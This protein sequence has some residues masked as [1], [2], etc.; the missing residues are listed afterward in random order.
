VGTLT[1]ILSLSLLMHFFSGDAVER[2]GESP[3]GVIGHRF[4][5]TLVFVFGTYGA[6]L[7]ALAIFIP[8][9]LYVLRL[10]LPVFLQ[11]AGDHLRQA[12]DSGSSFLGR[13]AA[14]LPEKYISNPV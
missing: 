4:G 9:L 6:F 5:Q 1:V 12:K 2:T 10:P 11:L 3:G 8:G 13:L 7:V 14:L